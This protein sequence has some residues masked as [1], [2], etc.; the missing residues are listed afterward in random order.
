[1]ADVAFV[2]HWPPDRMDEFTIAELMRWR[3][4]AVSRFNHVNKGAE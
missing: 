4:L 2:F 1:M 3:Q